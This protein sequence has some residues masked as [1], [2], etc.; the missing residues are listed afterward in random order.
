MQVGSRPHGR[1]LIR[2]CSARR[3]PYWCALSLAVYLRL[4][5][6][7]SR[8]EA[9][10]LQFL[11]GAAVLSFVQFWIVLFGLAYW[12]TFA[13]VGVAAIAAGLRIKQSY[14]HLLDANSC[15]VLRCF[16]RPSAS[17]ISSRRLSRKRAPMEPRTT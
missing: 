8:P 13:I 16:S 14:Q 10:V 17:T 12:Q 15:R 5:R 3:L 7:L 1:E 11:G 9:L 6:A 4:R 2:F